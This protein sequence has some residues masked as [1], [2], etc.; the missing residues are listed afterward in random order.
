MTDQDGQ[1]LIKRVTEA[2]LKAVSARAD[3]AVSFA[4]GAHG[5][6]ENDEGGQARLPAPSRRFTAAEMKS[7]RGEA[8]SAALKLRHHDPVLYQRQMPVG[9]GGTDLFDAAEQARVG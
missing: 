4:P 9:T 3:V 7:L 6:S 5:T 2:A 1:E 8:D